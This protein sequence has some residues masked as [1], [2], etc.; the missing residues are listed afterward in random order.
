MML[1]LLQPD[2]GTALV[3]IPIFLVMVFVSGTKIRYVSFL[4]L[5]AL[6]TIVMS[7]LP[8]VN[9]YISVRENGI[10]SLLVNPLF[11]RYLLLSLAVIIGIAA[12]GYAVFK[13]GYLYWIVYGSLIVFG[14]LVG[15]LG[16]RAVLKDY[17]LSR[18]I[19]FINPQVDPQGA[20][21]NVIQ[22][23]TAVGS[24]GLFGKGFLKG[25][26]SH[27]RYL[28]QQSTDFIFSIISE[29]WGFLGG[30]IIFLLFSIILIRGLVILTT[31]KDS[32]AVYLG[33]GVVGMIF[34]HVFINIGMAMG[35]MP[36]T[37]IP[38]FFL[39]YGGSSL[40]CALTG[41]ALLLNI[42]IRRY[43]Y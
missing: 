25:T 17:Q 40:W 29:E 42:H 20:G 5:I 23:V 34:F 28:P 37:G 15:E 32:F 41:I 4:I 30:V 27:Y 36:I 14:S 38:L 13:R 21:W 35:I 26:Q 24:G 43:K 11:I 7:L 9:R 12:F 22:S 33:A 16:V 2:M 8:A 10:L 39:S 18:L 31:A 1:V 19:V 3:Y 6:L